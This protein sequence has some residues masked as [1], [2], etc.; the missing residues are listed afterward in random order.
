MRPASRD[1][2]PAAAEP[3]LEMGDGA[4]TFRARL[5]ACRRLVGLSQEQ[6]AERSGLS[7]RAVG[8][9]E[10]VRNGA[11]AWTGF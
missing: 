10:R 7:I 9:V 4:G 1:N 6:L 8:N 11:N 2:I 5:C 3:S